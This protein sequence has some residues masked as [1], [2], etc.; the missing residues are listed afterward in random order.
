MSQSKDPAYLVSGVCCPAE[1]HVLRKA[2]D[3]TLGG[4]RYSFNP[5]S[6]EL[7]VERGIPEDRVLESLRGAGF[8]GKPRGTS[9][10]EEPFLRRHREGITA[11]VSAL[12]CVAGLVAGDVPS[13]IFLGAA[14][15][16]GGYSI[17]RR[18]LGAIRARALDMNVLICVAVAGALAIGK[19]EEGAAVIVL[20]AVSLMLESY[21]GTRTRRA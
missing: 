5:V 6:G 15:L 11:A 16:A 12:L 21:S 20:F 4:R 19:W 17:L 8:S 1:E 18:A 13:R 7:R 14:I 2:L 9:D 10:S 3:R